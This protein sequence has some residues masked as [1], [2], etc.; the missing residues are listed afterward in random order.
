MPLCSLPKN[1]DK[2]PNERFVHSGFSY[3]YLINSTTLSLGIFHRF[4]ILKPWIV[5][6]WSRSRSV[7][8]PTFK[9]SL[10]SLKVIIEGISLY[11]LKNSP[12]FFWFNI[13]FIT[14]SRFVQVSADRDFMLI[15]YPFGINQIKTWRNFYGKPKNLLTVRSN[16]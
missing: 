1:T 16:P 8:F 9:M 5:L 11:I 13:V 3:A 15:Y 2:S 4:P 12:F 14:P 6:L 7:F 10:H